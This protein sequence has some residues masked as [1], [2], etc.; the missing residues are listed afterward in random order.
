M[1]RFFWN[2]GDLDFGITLTFDLPRLKAEASKAW[3][4]PAHFSGLF[5]IDSY[6]DL[7]EIKQ[8]MMPRY[9]DNL[10]LCLHMFFHHILSFYGIVAQYNKVLTVHVLQSYMDLR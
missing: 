10:F 9:L 8:R 3:R 7:H 6:S 1:N 4:R 2:F 5:D